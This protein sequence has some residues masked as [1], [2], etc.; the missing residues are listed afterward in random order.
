MS[1][2]LLLGKCRA[3]MEQVDLHQ[4]AVNYC[5]IKAAFRKLFGGS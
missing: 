3:G 5:K 4:H 1:R 2:Y